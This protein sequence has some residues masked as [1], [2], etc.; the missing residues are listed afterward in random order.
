M[1][2]ATTIITTNF[3]RHLYTYGLSLLLALPL[4][5]QAQQLSLREAVQQLESENGKLQAAKALEIKA[6]YE[7]S[8]ARGGHLPNLSLN[9]NYTHINEDIRVDLNEV[10]NAIAGLHQI[11]QPGAVLGE[12][13]P[14]VQEQNF[15]NVNLTMQWPVFTGGKLN[16]ADEAA[17][18]IHS[19]SQTQ[20]ESTREELLAKLTESYFR[21]RMATEALQ[22]RRQV[23]ESVVAHAENAE[24]L[25]RNGMVARV[26][27]LN[28]EVAVSNAQREVQAAE[29][30]LALARSALNS[31]IGQESYDSLSTNLFA[32]Q[33]LQE[34]S[35]YQQLALQG[36]S[37][38]QYLRQQRQLAQLG[39]KKERLNYVPDVA[40]FG[41]KYVYTENLSVLEPNWAV[42]LNLSVNV[43]NGFKR[44]NGIRAATAQADQVSHLITQAERDIQTYVEQL[45]NELQKQQEQYRSLQ[46]NEKLAQ[47]LKFMRER[48][49]E[50]G[51]GT[52][53]DVIDATVN[54]SSIQLKQYQALYQYDT[55]YARLALL[56]SQWD[57][58]I[59]KL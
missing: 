39:V 58:L 31:L 36:H 21:V 32:P 26:E 7:V 57:E 3:M 16:L 17:R 5:A 27:Q 29:K 54:L 13:Q 2:S 46:Q 45:Y 47:E 12:W 53:V 52:S 51:M 15:G 44:E 42:G 38:L 23:L 41:K 19:A 8:Q 18:L 40:L 1:R 11:E 20:T 30:D 34:L 6:G 10:R 59:L 33:A 22:L 24:K 9:A 14:V 35:V 37:Q 28:A 25:Y 55:A 4:A 50:E 43:F 48:A 56:T 49:F